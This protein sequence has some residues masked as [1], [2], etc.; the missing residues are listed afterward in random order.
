MGVRPRPLVPADGRGPA[1]KGWDGVR[2]Q[3]AG[4]RRLRDGGRLHV[5]QLP[6]LH[7]TEISGYEYGELS[8]EFVGLV[9]A[10][11]GILVSAIA[12]IA[13]IVVFVLGHI[14]VLLLGITAAG[15]QMLRLEYVE[16]FQ[17]FYQ[18]GGEEYEPF[19]E[20]QTVQPAD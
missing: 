18:G 4:L 5:L 3:S 1:R 19:G 2:G 16:F 7:I 17:K 14:L 12:I 9:H 20:E 6:G 13:A 10:G 11:D 8:P 15:I